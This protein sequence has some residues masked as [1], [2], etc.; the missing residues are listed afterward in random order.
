M[1]CAN[2]A[3]LLLSR[4]AVRRKEIALRTALGAG[5][6]RLVRQ[7][8]T[9]SVLLAVLG[10]A[11]GLLLSFWGVNLLKSF[12]LENISEVKAIAVDAR[13]LVFTLLVSLLTGLIFGLAPA[14]QASNLDLNEMLKEGG[15]DSSSGRISPG[16]FD[17]MGIRLLRGRRS[18]S[19]G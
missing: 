10:A 16:Y 19:T 5:R 15:R 11:A 14:T 1:A 12:I 3:N 6:L 8:L 18:A 13:D 4:A 2:V 17:T 9:E 7:F